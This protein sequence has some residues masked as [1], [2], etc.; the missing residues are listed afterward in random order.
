MK[1]SWKHTF[2]WLILISGYGS[3]AQTGLSMQQAFEMALQQN[4]S[5]QIASNDYAISKRNN[6]LGNAGMLPS[7][8]GAVNQDNQQLDTKQKFLNGTE[9]NKNG[10]KT[11]LLNGSVELNW[12]LFNGMKMFATRN[13]LAELEAIGEAR[14]R[15]Q[16]ET[17]LT[18]V[19]RSYLE[20]VL[21]REQ[22]KSGKTFVEISEK[23]LEVAKARVLAGKSSKAEVLNAQVNLNS[24]IASYKRLE[25]QYKNSKLALNQLMGKEIT[26]DF[27][28]IDSLLPNEKISFEALKEQAVNNNSGVK[29]AR[30]NQDVAQYQWREIKGERYPVL[31]LKSGYIY[32][33]QQSE[34]GFLQSS[35]TNGFHYGAGLTMNIFNGFDVDRR[36]NNARLNYQSAGLLLKDSLL[37]LEIGLAQAYNVYLTNI[38][39]YRFEQNNVDVA[40]QN[41]E[42]AREQF[43][44][45]I[46]STNDLRVAQVNY[47]Q[48]I[49]RLLVSAFDAK[50]SE[51]ELQRLSGTL[52]KQ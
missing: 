7:I 35:Q 3:K 37:K 4:F 18:R 34:A 36:A 13:K 16:M 47:L 32:N 31:L 11:N 29:I 43:E 12:T 30:L 26:F 38:D 23:R 10:A 15:Q 24:D 40:R 6:S 25:T 8:N 44:Q 17:I 22:L 42:I 28:A 27:I 52:M 46:I 41:F 33:Q 9:N 20:V 2:V 45:G 51:V 48:T 50:V 21:A 14:L 19:A 5:I 39:L 1:L 49:N